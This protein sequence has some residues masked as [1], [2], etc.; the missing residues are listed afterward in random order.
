[1]NVRW[2]L[3]TACVLLC[4]LV[5]IRVLLRL[6]SRRGAAGGR[7]SGITGNGQSRG[8]ASRLRRIDDMEFRRIC[9]VDPEITVFHLTD[10]HRAEA[11]TELPGALMV[12]WAQ[13]E[14][15]VRWAPHGTSIV[16]YRPQEVDDTLLR[17]L[18]MFTHRHEVLLLCRWSAETGGQRRSA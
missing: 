7:N 17:R 14:E 6:F 1:M 11:A 10:E 16:I 2:M 5:A 15:A 13:L 4:F 3:G 12:T 18:S 9:T 8:N